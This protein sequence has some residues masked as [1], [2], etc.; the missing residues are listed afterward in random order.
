MRY[1]I[2]N[3]LTKPNGQID[4]VMSV[5][6]KLRTRDL[7]TASVIIDFRDLKIVQATLDGKTIPKDFD[8]IVKYYM[9]HYEQ[10][11]RR[12][13]KENGYEVEINT[14]ESESQNS[15]T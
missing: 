5:S 4:E 3:Y 15:A 12:L 7:Q 13:F 6:N 8:T 9:Q 10:V 1:L 14:H 2:F 11:I